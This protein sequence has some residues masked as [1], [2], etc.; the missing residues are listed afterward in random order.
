MKDLT[1]PEILYTTDYDKFKL[2]PD[3]RPISRKHVQSLVTSF[4]D[5][6]ELIR[7]RPILVN[8]KMEI[9]DGQHRLEAMKFL[10]IPVPYQMVPKITIATAQLMNALQRSWRL[11]DFIHSYAGSGRPEYQQIERWMD[12][13]TPAGPSVILAYATANG[14]NKS[15]KQLAR[16]GKLELL[17]N[18]VTED[19]LGKLSDL[20]V[21][22][23]YHDPFAMAFLRVLKTVKDYDHERMVAGIKELEIKRQPSTL[24]SLRELERAYNYK[25]SVNLARF[26]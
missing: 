24:D 14:R 12:T 10:N 1:T 18:D 2:L 21:S 16:L 11:I 6:P 17:P 13:F 4:Q 20:P 7:L 15:F 26:F 22:F 9:V 8:D 3:N 25:K 19:R 5:N 23:W